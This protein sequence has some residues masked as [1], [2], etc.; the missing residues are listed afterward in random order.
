VSSLRLVAQAHQA[1][2]LVLTKLQVQVVAV[3]QM[4][5]A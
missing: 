3:K 4:A 2:A 5:A 1:V